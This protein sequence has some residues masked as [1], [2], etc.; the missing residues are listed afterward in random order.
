MNFF[1]S[2][3]SLSK[4]EKGVDSTR[5]CFWKFQVRNRENQICTDC[6]SR[7]L[8]KQLFRW[9]TW[10]SRD[11]GW[12]NQARAY[13]IFHFGD[14]RFSDRFSSGWFFFC[15]MITH[16]FL[17]FCFLFFSTLK[18]CWWARSDG[19]ELKWRQ[20]KRNE[21]HASVQAWRSRAYQNE[22]NKKWNSTGNQGPGFQGERPEK[23]CQLA[24]NKFCTKNYGYKSCASWK[25]NLPLFG[26]PM[27]WMKIAEASAKH[28]GS[29]TAASRWDFFQ[30]NLGRIWRIELWPDCCASFE[31]C[32][33]CKQEAPLVVACVAC[34][35]AEAS[36][37]SIYEWKRMKSSA[38]E[39]GYQNCAL[40]LRKIAAVWS[41]IAWTQR[42]RRAC[43]CSA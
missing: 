2:K 25:L 33:L 42:L 28:P 32:R 34:D 23:V 12:P 11:R 29:S 38:V 15:C 31:P 8:E 7:Q 22:W 21:K 39:T 16:L 40:S 14:R 27:P 18:A 26:G 5:R 37:I 13:I 24:W 35:L 17:S 6:R 4:T 30:G 9:H 43:K 10:D 41:A 20:K 3:W 1:F 19:L 36:A